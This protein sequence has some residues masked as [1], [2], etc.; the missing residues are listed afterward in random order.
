MPQQ[1]IELCASRGEARALPLQEA[2]NKRGLRNT[3]E[4]QCLHVCLMQ[5]SV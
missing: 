1:E 5:D 4:L 2:A 3:G